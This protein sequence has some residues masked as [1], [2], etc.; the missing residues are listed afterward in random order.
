MGCDVRAHLAD[1]IAD[2][3]PPGDAR[4][5]VLHLDTCRDCAREFA[6]M[7]ELWRS[8]GHL[9]A[10]APDSAAMRERF[11]GMLAGVQRG[12]A[13]ECG[14]VSGSGAVG[15]AGSSRVARGPSRWWSAG[16]TTIVAG[17]AAAVLLL[18]VGIGRNLAPEPPA[19]DPQV[20]ALRDELGQM[21]QLLTLTLLQ[22]QSASD[23]L[24][25]VTTSAE[26]DRPGDELAAAL[27]D[28]LMHDPNVN[29]RMATVDALKRFA[30]RD[31]VRRGV[32]EAIGRQTSPLVQ[33]ALIDFVVETN[34]RDAA[35]ALRHLSTDPAADAAVRARAAAGL[36]QVGA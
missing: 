31:T 5:V 32:I 11:D 6:V 22:Q 1:Y 14:A 12:V 8:L 26:I 4:T 34:S 15:G 30:D 24:Q 25:A 10:D 18:G 28:A 19:V 23:R 7:A 27:L 35:D 21:R 2:S 29:V 9:P 3:L 17:A 36:T 33:I 13:G 20:S 16:R